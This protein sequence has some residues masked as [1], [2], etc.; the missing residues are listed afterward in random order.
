MRTFLFLSCRDIKMTIMTSYFRI[1]DDVIKFAFTF[2]KISTHPIFL[3]RFSIIWLESENFFWKIC[4]FD[5]VFNQALPQKWL[6]WQQWMAYPQTFNFKR[7]PIYRSKGQKVSWKSA[8]P[9]LTYLAKTLRSTPPV[10]IGTPDN[11]SHFLRPLPAY[12]VRS[13]NFEAFL[14]FFSTLFCKNWRESPWKRNIP[15][16]QEC[17]AREE[18]SNSCFFKDGRENFLVTLLIFVRHV[19][20]VIWRIVISWP[21]WYPSEYILQ[22]FVKLLTIQL[23]NLIK[24]CLT[25]FR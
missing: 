8:E 10:Q 19:G 11:T 14:E 15:K 6:S 1:R 24:F 5:N 3:P 9:F 23:L 7:W 2:Y 22:I 13:G 16:K 4:L 20:A 21:T 17:H 25:M 12:A 18:I